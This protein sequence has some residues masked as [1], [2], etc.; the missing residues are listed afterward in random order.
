MK[1]LEH[2]RSLRAIA[3]AMTVAACAGSTGPLSSTVDRPASTGDA[4]LVDAGADASP[5]APVPD[6]G[7]SARRDA[8]GPIVE[9]LDAATLPP[10]DAA[11][12]PPFDAATSA[13]PSNARVIFDSDMSSDWDDV[14]DIAVLHGL[15][16]LGQVEILA[17][18]NS[19]LN[20]GTMLCMDA[21][22][23]YYGKPDIP[24]GRRPDVGGVGGYPGQ[25]A[26]EFPHGPETKPTEFPLAVDVYRRVLAAQPAKSVTILTT[27]FLTNLKALLLSGPDQYSPLN[28]RELVQAKVTMLA[29]AGGAFP[30]GDEFNFRSSGD[31]SAYAVL[32][33]WPSRVFYVGFSVGQAVK[34]AGLLREAAADSPIRRVY[35]DIEDQIPYS[36]WGQ[37]ASYYLARQSEGLFGA[38]TTGR[39]VV[40]VSGHNAWKTDMDPSG[41]REQSYLLEL[42]RSPVRE[43]LNA[44][45][46]LA[47][48]KGGA[49]APGDPS[50]LRASVQGASVKLTW[51]DNAYNEGG[52]EIERG[53]NGTF[54]PVGNAARDATTFTDA[55]P[56]RVANVAYRVRA[57]NATGRSRAS[58]VWIYGSWTELNFDKPGDLPLY[59][60]YQSSNLRW[61]RGGDV[62]PNHVA[63]NEDSQHDANVTIDVD[64]AA[65]GAQGTFYV[66]PFY[67][68]ENNWYRLRANETETV[69]ERRVAGTI[70]QIGAKGAGVAIGNGTD[71]QPWQIRT[72]AQGALTFSV[73]GAQVLSVSEP[74]QLTSGKIALGGAARTPLWES[75]RFQTP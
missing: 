35:V 8:A 34:T 4:A 36:S 38:V 40:E 30:E 9:P 58:T 70:S 13:Q 73:S 23:T 18:A 20:G 2:V 69:F 31:D 19:S 52:F 65:L 10:F 71:L 43:G 33:D 74:L 45:L 3:A 53:I 14:G 28:G 46:M 68:D 39:N 62:R 48:N 15:A 42:F 5:L 26:S 75:F 29:C 56:P 49:T 61:S 51:T 21:I 32:N 37:I 54:T 25:I 55:A 7:A 16:S 12:L 27:G 47:P 6:A 64:V 22:N 1:Y 67:R 11:A 63:I 66:Y 24:I 72:T 50:N 57:F 41:D 17:M 59:S 60:Y 44:L